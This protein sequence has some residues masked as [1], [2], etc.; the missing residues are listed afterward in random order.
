MNVF[1]LYNTCSMFALL[2]AL[3]T[4]ECR[5]IIMLLCE[6]KINIIQYLRKAK[7]NALFLFF[8]QY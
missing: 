3:Q 8:N 6:E 5:A 1:V 7:D 2:L 4:Y